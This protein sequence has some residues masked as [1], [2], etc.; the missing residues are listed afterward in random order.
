MLYR[1][2]SR[3]AGEW[4]PNEDGSQPRSR[5]DQRSCSSS[6]ARSTA[7]SPTSRRSPRSRPRGAACRGRPST[8]ASAS[9]S[10]GTSAGC[11][12]RSTYLEREP[13]HRK[14]HHDELT[15]RAIYHEQRELRAA[16]LAR[17]GR[18]R[19]R[20][21]DREDAGRPVAEATRRCACCTATSGR[22]PA[23]S[24][25]SWATRSACGASG[26]TTRSSTGRSASTRRTPASR[27][28]SAISTRAYRAH[29]RAARR[30]TASRSGFSWLV[31]DDRDGGVLAY[32]RTGERRRSAGAASSRTS[33]RCRARAIGSACRAPGS[34]ARSSTPTRTIYGGSG[35][36]NRG[37]MHAEAVAVPRPRAVA[38]RDRAAARRSWCSWHNSGSDA[39]ASGS[40]STA[41]STSRRARTR[42]SRRSSR[43]RARTRIATGTSG[44]PPSA[45]GR[46]RAARVVDS[47]QPDHPD[48]RQLPAHELQRRAD[49]DV[50][51]RAPR[52]RRPRGARR[53]RS[54]EPRAVRRPRLGDGA[55]LQ[56]HDHAARVAAR[57]RDA[58]A[59]GHRRLPHALRPRARGHVAA[60]VRGRYRRRSRRSPPRASRSPCSR[61][62]RR[63][64]G[65]RRAA[66]GARPRSI[67]GAR[68]STRCRRGA[69]SICSSTTARPRRRSRSSA[70]SPTATRSSRG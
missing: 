49:A 47:Q 28:G 58:G 33:R 11:T 44:S 12:T 22:C 69:R 54:R 2:Y 20:L 35:V 9:A 51:A 37:G 45:T 61:R 68:T 18:P 4:V 3:K 48:R 34:G 65:G 24:C 14:W 56:P 46:T 8:A 5:R 57:S 39:A 23:R 7:R 31:G 30:A 53:G 66:S 59:L 27:A 41:T 50:V 63:R 6:T 10:S 62:T 21:A 19:Q 26:T 42:G 40:A 70:C 43:S 32:L 60:R 67:R 38:R 1:D 13:I 25:C 55:G 15:F 64:R 16:A 29:P 17:R 36:G 52:A